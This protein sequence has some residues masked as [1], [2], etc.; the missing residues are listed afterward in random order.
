M[1]FKRFLANSRIS[2]RRT[3]SQIGSTELNTIKRMKFEAP[4][5][6]FWIRTK[7]QTIINWPET[8]NCKL[9]QLRSI[10]HFRRTRLL[11]PPSSPKQTKIYLVSRTHR[12][13]SKIIIQSWSIIRKLLVPKSGTK[14]SRKTSLI[15]EA[16][17]KRYQLL[18][19][20]WQRTKK[21]R[22]KGKTANIAQ[23]AYTRATKINILQQ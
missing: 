6:I 19:T 21:T 11:L 7:Q 12:A 10:I 14:I 23:T 1:E 15:A 8:Q 9:N 2:L 5:K 22:V 13:R 17:L 18:L 16:I 20:S 4:I 3:L